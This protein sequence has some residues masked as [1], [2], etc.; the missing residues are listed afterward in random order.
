MVFRLTGA[1]ENANAIVDGAWEI[2]GLAKVTKRQT[3]K[4]KK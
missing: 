3:S 4:Y 2:S 1:N